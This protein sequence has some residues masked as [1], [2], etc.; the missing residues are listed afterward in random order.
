AEFPM[1]RSEWWCGEF[2]SRSERMGLVV[3]DRQKTLAPP[4]SQ[5][6]LLLS[7][8]AAAERLG[9]NAKTLYNLTK[10]G[11]VMATRIGSRVLYSPSSLEEFVARNTSSASG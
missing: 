11:K 4:I 1:T 9:V 3:P 2:S 7:Q 8:R 6:P 10:Q 5:K